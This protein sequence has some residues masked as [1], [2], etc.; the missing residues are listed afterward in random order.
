MKI[1]KDNEG[2]E[3]HI[4]DSEDGYSLMTVFN[5]QGQVVSESSIQ[6]SIT[7]LLIKDFN[8]TEIQPNEAQR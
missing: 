3:Y 1:Y 2:S 5:Q 6:A 7:D 8:L 4:S